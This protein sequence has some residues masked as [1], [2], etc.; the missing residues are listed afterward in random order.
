MATHVGGGGGNGSGVGSGGGGGGSGGGDASPSLGTLL[1]TF[2]SSSIDAATRA[3]IQERLVAYQNSSDCIRDTHAYLRDT[4]PPV[5]AAE[6]LPAHFYLGALSVYAKT[7]FFTSSPGQRDALFTAAL[8]FLSACLPVDAAAAAAPPVPPYVVAKAAAVIAELGKREWLAATPRPGGGAEAGVGG[9]RAGGAD[10]STTGG[11]RFEA[12]MFTVTGSVRARAAVAV[13]LIDGVGDAAAGDL[14]SGHY[15]RLRQLLLGRGGALVQLLF[16]AAAGAA[17]EAGGGSR[18]GGV[19]PAEAAAAVRSLGGMLRLASSEASS[20]VAV[21]A[22]AAVRHVSSM[23]AAAS[24]VRATAFEVLADVH[25]AGKNRLLASDRLWADSLGHVATCWPSLAA[26]PPATPGEDA[27]EEAVALLRAAVL[28]AESVVG[29][30]VSRGSPSHGAVSPSSVAAAPTSPPLLRAL[31]SLLSF[32][33]AVAGGGAQRA[34]VFVAAL[35]AWLAVLEPLAD[36][37]ADAPIVHQLHGGL[38][39]L[40]QMCVEK[41]LS[42]SNGAVLSALEDWEEDDVGGGLDG[43]DGED[44]RGEGGSLRLSRDGVAEL[45]ALLGLGDPASSGAAT[46]PF[47]EVA[48][49]VSGTAVA[50]GSADEAAAAL[51]DR[52]AYVAKNLAVVAAVA[53]LYPTTSARGL[54]GSVVSLLGVTLAAGGRGDTRD[55][56]TLLQMA[57]DVSPSLEPSTAAAQGLLSTVCRVLGASDNGVLAAAFRVLSCLTD[58]INAAGGDGGG[59]GGGLPTLARVASQ[60]ASSVHPPLSR[61]A[62]A[63]LCRLAATPVAATAFGTAPPLSA[64]FVAVPR[65]AGGGD[66]RAA[67]LASAAAFRWALLPYGGSASVVSRLAPEEWAQRSAAWRAFATAALITPLNDAFGESVVQALARHAAPLLRLAVIIRATFAA[68]ATGAGGARPADALWSAGGQELVISARRV[69]TICAQV[70]HAKRITAMTRRLGTGAMPGAG[71]AGG[72]GGGA[73]AGGAAGGAGGARGA[74]ITPDAETDAAMT[75]GGAYVAVLASALPL[76]RRREP[77][78]SRDVLQ[79]G[80]ALLPPSP[81]AAAE[82]AA[83]GV[84]G[85]REAP[86]RGRP[87]CFSALSL[88]SLARGELASGDGSADALVLPSVTLALLALQ[89]QQW[90]PPTSAV[91]TAVGGGASSAGDDEGGHSTSVAIAAVSLLEEALNGHWHLFWP[92]SATAAGAVES[93][94]GAAASPAAAAAAIAASKATSLVEVPA[95]PEASAAYDAALKALADGV[96]GTYGGAQ[97]GARC[98]SALTSLHARRRLFTR[99]AAFA[100]CGDVAPRLLAMALRVAGITD[101]DAPPSSSSSA[102]I[103]GSDRSEATLPCATVLAPLRDDA[104]AVAAAAAA[105]NWERFVLVWLP[106]VLRGVGGGGGLSD[107][108]RAQLGDRFRDARDR[109]SFVRAVES[110]ANDLRFFRSSA[111]RTMQR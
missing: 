73:G 71:A 78:L 28:Y 31:D 97:V 1:S 4:P 32:T 6:A 12:I 13:A 90:H 88:L 62:A 56:R 98:L 30:F 40:A 26:G 60:C 37:A 11:S 27:E 103:G 83:G 29:R 109:P 72:T 16:S 53:R 76:A 17:G 80:T 87:S 68:A 94:G 110:T 74:G 69:L 38:T 82:A 3:A 93:A 104:L 91:G 89:S 22:L 54:A 96:G 5:T 85:P 86:L 55:M 95:G 25:G 81:T 51:S 39:A 59:G 45:E 19:T 64:A 84:G 10:I 2:Y 101:D 70:L 52:A 58:A 18:G 15:T 8:R 35:D 9:G 100:T 99:S 41:A 42:R 61:Y 108:Q 36:A 92:V 65:V 50:A 34:S 44:V 49:V 47:D 107:A 66:R 24:A 79:L 46:T 48:L 21:A 67:A 111:M 57:A 105:A 77:S 7:Q 33:S 106:A 20:E 43:D 102:G 14:L 23:P 75:I 63:F